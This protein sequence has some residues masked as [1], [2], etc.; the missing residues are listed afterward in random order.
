LAAFDSNAKSLPQ[1]LSRRTLDMRLSFPPLSRTLAELAC[2]LAFVLSAST[3]IAARGAVVVSSTPNEQA[4]LVR[5]LSPGLIVDWNIDCIVTRVPGLKEQQPQDV[6]ALEPGDL[7]DDVS[8]PTAEETASSKESGSPEAA[9]TDA[10]DDSD[11][12]EYK[13]GH[14][15][16]RYGNYEYNKSNAS[17][18]S[19]ND[20]AITGEESS[21]DDDAAQSDDSAVQDDSSTDKAEMPDDEN[22]VAGDDWVNGTPDDAATA[23][24]DSSDQSE[25][26]QEAADETAAKTAEDDQCDCH[27]T[28]CEAM[29]AIASHWADEL[30]SQYGLRPSQVTR[31]LW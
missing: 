11:Y 5:W 25:Q 30:L 17:P 21:K 19:D 8:Q 18:E 20:P 9:D 7:Q 6:P 29:A 22:Q 1:Q 27:S 14:Y 10:S 2:C 28:I 24:N 26:V 31:L 16:R 15:G 3:G 4:S 13:Y 12:M 23:Q